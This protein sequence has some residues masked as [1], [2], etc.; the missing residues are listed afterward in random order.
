MGNKSDRPKPWKCP[1]GHL[2][3]Y[4]DRDRS[5]R[6]LLIFDDSIDI[7]I[8][9]GGRIPTVRVI[10]RGPAPVIRCTICR[11]ERAWYADQEAMNRLI[12]D[13]LESR[14]A[15]KRDRS[16]DLPDCLTGAPLSP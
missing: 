3:G 11:A 4:V 8:P 10:I 14:K 13:V 9:S 5:G 6:K 12:D 7:S 16:E 1:N 15:A 2:V